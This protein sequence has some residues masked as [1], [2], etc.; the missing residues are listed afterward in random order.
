MYHIRTVKHKFLLYGGCFPQ[1][2]RWLHV[3]PYRIEPRLLPT[4]PYV[5]K[6]S[7]LMGRAQPN[8][9]IHPNKVSEWRRA[10]STTNERVRLS[11]NFHQQATAVH[12]QATA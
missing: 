5:S 8:P 2:E 9:P 11:S 10:S 4:H 1:L 6:K 12:Q 7:K 3:C